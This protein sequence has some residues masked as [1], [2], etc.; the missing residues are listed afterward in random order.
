MRRA[1]LLSVAAVS[2]ALSWAVFAPSQKSSSS[3]SE[4]QSITAGDATMSDF[5]PFSTTLNKTTNLTHFV[6]EHA[7]GVK[8][9]LHSAKRNMDVLCDHAEGDSTKTLLTDATLTGDVHMTIVGKSAGKATSEPQRATVDG[10]TAH[11]DAAENLLHVTGEVVLNDD[12]P[13]IS[14]TFHATGSSADLRLSP[15]GSHGDPLRSGELEGPVAIDITGV[16]TDN[17]GGG[18]KIPF[19]IRATSNHASFDYIARTLTLTGHVKVVSDD[20]T[21]LASMNGISN[22]VIQFNEDGSIAGSQGNGGEP[23]VTTYNPGSDTHS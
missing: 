13:G 3:S 22:L 11:Y 4:E 18:K 12:D 5:G 6:F 10:S 20:Q 17:D 9:R 21:S 7:K 8:L 15:Q 14:R 16:R 1:S 23:G 2:A 19:H